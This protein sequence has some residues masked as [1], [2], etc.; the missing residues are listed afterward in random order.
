MR[1]FLALVV[2]V[3]LAAACGGTSSTQPPPTDPPVA[4]KPPAGPRSVVLSIVGTN[5]LHG[6]VRPD[7]DGNRGG[8]AIF[9]GYVAN[10]RA[11]RAADGGSVLLFDGGDAFQGTLESNINEG[12]MVVA[13]Y[14]ALG[15]DA[16][17]I[18]NHEFDYGPSG[19]QVTVKLPTDDPR[20]AIKARAAEAKFPV[21][22]ANIFDTA[23][24]KVVDWP[25]VH[26]TVVI[27]RAGVKIGVIGLTTLDTPFSTMTA[28]VKDLEFRPLA[29]TMTQEAK[30]LRDE[31]AQVVV[32]VAH[33]G[34][35][36]KSFDDP[37]D[38]SSC[39]PDAEMFVALKDVPQGAID[40]VVAGHTHDGVA[41]F[42]NGVAM[43]E[44]FSYGKAFGR[45]DLTVTDGKV[46]DV[47]IHQ[48]RE[49]CLT[50]ARGTV[51]CDAKAEGE[52][53]PA[54]YE[55]R[56][57]SIDKAVA[58]AIAPA[59]ESAATRRAEALG[60]K[61][62]TAILK[63]YGLESP[64][65]NFVADL[66][67]EARPKADLAITNGGGLRTNLN[68]GELTYGGFYELYPFDNRYAMVTTKARDVADM[69]RRNLMS[70]KGILSFGG[71]RA[72]AVCKGKE[73]VVTLRRDNGKPIK[74]NDTLVVA[75]SDFLAGGGADGMGDGK[76]NIVIEDQLVREELVKVLRKRG[77]ITLRGDDPKLYDPKS[78]RLA[79]P[80][81]RPVTCP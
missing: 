26:P 8:V 61:L 10:L 11:A 70:D 36:C 41:H 37:K 21:L 66:M 14:N 68:E 17:V 22:T 6:N 20:G 76:Q 7:S 57:V 64:L 3:S 75:T 79:Y 29:E 49:L 24:K 59:V 28:N 32:V 45:V 69:L 54:F 56:P 65:G 46:S 16:M 74:P 23:T 81:K 63:S 31:G 34:G 52:R 9:G 40:V 60:P 47:K 18:G 5:D 19:D 67:K 25:N 30:R 58:D 53:E 1:R 62:E 38:I 43:I 80:G 77:K 55:G 2:V 27:E 33:A 39:L 50:V 15:Y 48:P 71:V 4:A 44:G 78:P 42:V 51:R 72:T 12:A 73:L 35:K 13:A